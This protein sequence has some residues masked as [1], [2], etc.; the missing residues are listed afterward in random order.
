MFYPAQNIKRRGFT[1]IELLL[2]VALIGL[3]ALFSVRLGS[4]FIWR[5]DLGQAQFSTVTA[6]RRAQSLAQA[7]MNDSDWGVHVENSQLFLFK[8]NNF[9][10]R[11]VESD[12]EYDLGSVV[13]SAPVDVI[14][15]KFSGQP[16]QNSSEIDLTII[17]GNIAS[18]SVNEEGTVSY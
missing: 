7:Q 8:G 3:I 13:A 16:Y 9:E 18:I 14:Y 2:V 6:L 10:N 17:G 4:D 11:D 15:H 12:E 1:L 5:T